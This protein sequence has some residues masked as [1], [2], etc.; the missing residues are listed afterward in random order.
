MGELRQTLRRKLR[1]ET[2]AV[3]KDIV[4]RPQ[5]EIMALLQAE[6]SSPPG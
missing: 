3:L 1:T 5:A 2:G 6:L 4:D